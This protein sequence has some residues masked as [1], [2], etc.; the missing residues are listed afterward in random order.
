MKVTNVGQVCM[1]WDKVFALCTDE[2]LGYDTLA[3][4]LAVG[5]SRI[6]VW[7]GRRNNVV[8]VML[9]KRL[10]VINP[11]DERLVSTLSLRRPM[12]VSPQLSLYDCLNEFQRGVS[13]LAI[14]CDQPEL[15]EQQSKAG[16]ELTDEIGI[17]GIVTLEDLLEMLIKEEIVDETD[18]HGVMAEL[19]GVQKR[20]RRVAAFRKAAMHRQRTLGGASA[21]LGSIK[22]ERNRKRS[23]NRASPRPGGAG[24]LGNG[25]SGGVDLH[26]D[27]L[28]LV[29]SDTRHS[30]SH[31][32]SS[33]QPSASLLTPGSARSDG[34]YGSTDDSSRASSVS[35][36]TKRWLRATERVVS[37]RHLAGKDAERNDG[38]AVGDRKAGGG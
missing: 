11:E 28:R 1:E 10:I 3:R 15:A 31:S 13:H 32:S 27:K 8:G 21:A 24:G 20:K 30:P 19:A 16:E 5:H 34:G 29:T 14:V 35:I 4:M 37:E 2:R 22:E 9:T 23:S 17:R 25:G 36:T 33:P 12:F 38:V 18:P 6:P 7:S 26:V